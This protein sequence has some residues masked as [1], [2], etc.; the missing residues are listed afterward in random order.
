VV[1]SLCAKKRTGDHAGAIIDFSK[2]IELAPDFA[3]AYRGRGVAMIKLGRQ[4]EGR[5]DLEKARQPGCEI[6]AEELSSD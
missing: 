6:A 1:Q 2:A 4:E 5:K 3:K